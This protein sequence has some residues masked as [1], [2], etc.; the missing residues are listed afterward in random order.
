MNV[1]SVGAGLSRTQRRP[2]IQACSGAEGNECGRTGDGR[3]TAGA[4]EASWEYGNIAN[5]IAVQVVSTAMARINR[6]SRARGDNCNR[7]AFIS[8][9]SECNGWAHAILPVIR[10]LSPSGGRRMW[11]KTAHYVCQYRALYMTQT[12]FNA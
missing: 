5:P 8:P 1:H 12:S 3:S 7:V 11:R 10:D 9:S 2:A 6:A 4:D